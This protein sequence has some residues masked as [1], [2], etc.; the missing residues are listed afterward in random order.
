MS[1]GRQV[2]NRPDNPGNPD[3]LIEREALFSGPI[4][5]PATLKG[6]GEIDPQYPERIFKMA[7]EYSKAEVKG[8][9]IE[10]MAI[11]LGMGF[12]FLTCIAGLIFSV[13]LAINGMKAESITAAIAGVSPIIINALS[14]FRRPSK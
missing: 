8:R 2:T 5:P 3:T 9:N 13:V 10:S 1:N 4:P 11:I 6:Y 14:N 12:S 7:E